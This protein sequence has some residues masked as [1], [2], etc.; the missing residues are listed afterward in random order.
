MIRLLLQNAQ[1]ITQ[2][3]ERGWILIEDGRIA[4]LGEGNAPAFDGAEV[5]DCG[6]KTALP[7][8]IDL[9]VH[10]A[11]G[12]D[13]MDA[14]PQAV[15]D[16][17]HFYATHGVTAFLATTMTAP[18]DATR[19]AL[20]NAAGCVGPMADGAAL[21]G[22]HL[23]GPYLNVKMKGAQDGQYIRRADPAVYRDWLNIGVIR[24]ITVAP[25][26]PENQAFIRDCVARGINVSLGH[27]AATYEDVQQAVSLGARQATHTFNAMTGVHHRSPGTAG[28]VLSMDE[29]T[30]ELIADT[31]HVHPAILKLVVRAKGTD[32]VVL[33]TDAI[34]GAGM[35]DGQYELGGQAVT[36]ANHTATLA[37]GT[38]AGSVLTMDRALRNVLTA[39]G[40]SLAEA[41]PMTSANAARQIGVEDRKGRLVAGYDADIV[42]LDAQNNVTLTIAQGRVLYRA[43]S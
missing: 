21:L 25:E 39:T 17:A 12:R 41:W 22:V 30:C 11:V 16:M 40:L 4:R 18:D 19:R 29:I 2:G 33:I 5:L 38:L 36:V 34:M 1:L 43:S 7:G 9:H 32:R 35:P 13:T 6:G 26:F 28:A 20:E 10:G 42:L 14:T 27:T 23:E 37:D 8:F 3:W 15:H 31:I 24:Q